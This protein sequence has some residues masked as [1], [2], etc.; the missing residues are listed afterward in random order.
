MGCVNN[1]YSLIVAL[2]F[3]KAE[4]V[5]RDSNISNTRRIVAGI[6]VVMMFVVVLFSVFCIAVEANHDCTGDDCPICACIQQCENILNQV[7]DGV[8]RGSI[9]AP[10]VFLLLFV[11]FSVYSILQETLVSTKVRLN[12]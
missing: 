4:T 11:L 1:A 6:M 9:V 3:G 7:G 8:S 10:V 2:R 12:N 5:M